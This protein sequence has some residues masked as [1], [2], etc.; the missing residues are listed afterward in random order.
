MSGRGRW[1]REGQER[2]ADPRG[3]ATH[4][5]RRF[6][7]NNLGEE[8]SQASEFCC[9]VAGARMLRLCCVGPQPEP[10]W[11][12]RCIHLLARAQYVWFTITADSPF[13]M[14]GEGLERWKVHS[15]LA[16]NAVFAPCEAYR[17]GISSIVTQ[18]SVHG[19]RAPKSVLTG[20]KGGIRQRRAQAAVGPQ[21]P[22]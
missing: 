10:H 18:Q 20:K 16:R 8:A 3:H 6:I 14:S 9:S 12:S 7:N 17:G 4:L 2:C 15:S 13:C 1:E 11:L 22:R 19:G 21:A 5:H